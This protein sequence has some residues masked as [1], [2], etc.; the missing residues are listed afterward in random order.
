VGASGASAKGAKG[1][2]ARASVGPSRRFIPPILADVV[3]VAKDQ[4]HD[5]SDNTESR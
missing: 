1:A 4:L 5:S 3:V 2:T